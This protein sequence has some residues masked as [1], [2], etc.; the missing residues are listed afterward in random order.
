MNKIQWLIGLFITILLAL[1]GWNVHSL[2]SR[3]IEHNNVARERDEALLKRIEGLELISLPTRERL[4][5]VETEHRLIVQ[6]IDDT[7]QTLK[8]L[9]REVRRR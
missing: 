6:S 8:E 9:V 3:M 2:E 5:A 7:N 4:A 1:I